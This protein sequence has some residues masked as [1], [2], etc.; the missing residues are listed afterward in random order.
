MRYRHRWRAHRRLTVD[1]GQ[2]AIH[3]V[4]V[5]GDQELAADREAR[6]F[7]RFR[8]TGFLQQF[9]RGATGAN[10]DKFGLDD[11]IDAAVF[12]TGNGHIPGVIRIAFDAADFTAQ[13]QREVVFA[14]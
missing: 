13:L 5:F 14:L 8:D 9:Q 3:H 2:M 4:R 12:Q 7:R 11:L 6:V 1:L 10:K